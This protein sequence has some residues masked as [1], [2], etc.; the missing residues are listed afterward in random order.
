MR[1]KYRSEF[2]KYIRGQFITYMI[3]QVVFSVVGALGYVSFLI[4][5]SPTVVFLGSIAMACI[6][7]FIYAFIQATA[8]HFI[9]KRESERRE[10]ALSEYLERCR[11]EAERNGNVIDN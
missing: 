8:D 2:D 6:G 5:I 11:R 10:K 1:T 9:E 7:I 3:A 4:A